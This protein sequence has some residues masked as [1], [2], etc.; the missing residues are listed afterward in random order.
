VK[1]AIL[2]LRTAARQVKIIGSYPIAERPK[3]I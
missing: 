3:V 1:A 2:E